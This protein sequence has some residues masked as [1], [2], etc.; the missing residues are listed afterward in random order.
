MLRFSRLK[1]YLKDSLW[2]VPF[3]LL[4]G[5]VALAVVVAYLDRNLDGGPSV[6]TLYGGS[7]EGARTILTTIAASMLSLAVLVF[8]I[9]LI[10]LQ[11][12]SSQ[13]TPRVLSLFLEDRWSKIAMGVFLGTFSYA[14]VG[15]W[16]VRAPSDSDDAFVPVLMVSVAFLAVG[17]SLLTFLNYINR[18]AQSIRLESVTTTIAGQ[19]RR[20]IESDPGLRAPAENGSSAAGDPADCADVA[21]EG[22][23]RVISAPD[24]GLLIGV[25]VDELA[26]WAQ[27]HDSV[28][29]ILLPLGHFVPEGAPLVRITGP[30]TGEE[31][32][33]S[34]VVSIGSERVV[35]L[36]PAY[37][38][39]ELV[40]IA[41][42]ALSPGVNEPGSA[43]VVLDRIHEILQRVGSSEMPGS[44]CKDTD[45][46]VRVVMPR[47]TWDGWVSLALREIL[48]YGSDSVQVCQRVASM[49]EDLLSALEPSRHDVL[50]RYLNEV[51]QLPGFGRAY[52]EWSEIPLQP[53]D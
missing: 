5:F 36:D 35:A 21:G 10:V 52:L 22:P 51:R 12:A 16:F 6:L 32:P 19:V 53:K 24:S 23:T 25:S 2:F 33:L 43:V 48:D 14:L 7:A 3:M 20:S 47:L 18:V 15:L 44:A 1:E 38:L 41:V 50:R 8:S 13:L 26:E 31:F 27:K 49:L 17:V 28:I 9:T 30:D 46:K 29:E 39:H 11:L 37:G 40:D 34:D 42:R 4:L 45:G